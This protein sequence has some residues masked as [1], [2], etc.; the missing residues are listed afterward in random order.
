MSQSNWSLLDDLMQSNSLLTN[1]DSVEEL[2]SD[3]LME[4]PHFLLMTSQYCHRDIVIWS[5]EWMLTPLSLQKWRFKFVQH[6]YLLGRTL[7]S[8]RAF[9]RLCSPN[10]LYE[11]GFWFCQRWWMLSCL[12]PTQIHGTFYVTCS[13]NN[14][15]LVIAYDTLT[16]W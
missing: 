3:I 9:W 10:S 14:Y 5:E 1:S 15:C 11:L 16:A 7:G 4:V 8:M 6:E 2:F 12:N 13:C